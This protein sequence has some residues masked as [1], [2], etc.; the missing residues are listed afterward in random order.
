[1]DSSD[2]AAQLAAEYNG[3]YVYILLRLSGM[4]Q[5]DIHLLALSQI[6]VSPLHLVRY[7]PCW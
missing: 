7:Q 5:T 2:A 6:T 1:M 4:H 3:L